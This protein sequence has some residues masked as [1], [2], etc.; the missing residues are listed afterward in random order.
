MIKALKPL[1]P[2]I[3]LVRLL[4]PQLLETMN[5]P[6]SRRRREVAHSLVRRLISF[7]RLPL[8][9]DSFQTATLSIGYHFEKLRCWGRWM[10]SLER[11]EVQQIPLLRRMGSVNGSLRIGRGLDVTL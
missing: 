7:E 9:D 4:H 8:E 1:H 10:A 3:L 11:M 6:D 2:G 5:L